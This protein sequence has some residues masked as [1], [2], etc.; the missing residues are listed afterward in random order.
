MLFSFII[1]SFYHFRLFFLH[2]YKYS[3]GLV[4][5]SLFCKYNFVLAFFSCSLFVFVNIAMF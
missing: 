3:F 2:F 1:D 4:V 5:L